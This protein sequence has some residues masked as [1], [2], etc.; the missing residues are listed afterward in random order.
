MR[1]DQFVSQA[2]TLSRKQAQQL[3][4]AQCIRV[5][6]Q[7]VTQAS[8]LV[9]NQAQVYC[10]DESICLP[11]ALYLMLHKPLG[12]ISATEDPSQRTVLDLIQHPHVQTLHPV[13]RL[14]KDTTG[15]ILLTNEG[16]WSHRISAP[17]Q[18]VPKV[19]L[20]KLA[21]PLNRVAAKQLELG[22]RLHGE[23]QL[24]AA[25]SIEILPEQ[26]A[27]LTI[28]Q[29]KYH[30]VKR[31]FAAVG[32]RV[33]QLHREQIGGLSLDP[34]LMAGEWRFLTELE[35]QLVFTPLAQPS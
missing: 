18:Q 21:E 14:D 9:P 20:A 34:T 23:T 31:M 19:Y 7:I 15:L 28:H 2:L 17:R 26:Y 33:E 1:L 12:V 24:V 30:Q 29:G 8:T 22:V 32:N 25:S 5:N 3:I 11:G 16:Q 13:G 4:R 10:E 6:G 27:R 35:T